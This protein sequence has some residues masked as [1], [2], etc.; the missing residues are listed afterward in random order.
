MAMTFPNYVIIN[1]STS[2]VWSDPAVHEPLRR[3]IAANPGNLIQAVTSRPVKIGRESLIVEAGLT[4][5]NRS[6]P[7]AVKQYRPRTLWKALAALFRPAKAMQNW[8]KAEFLLS[9]DIATPQPLLACRPRGWTTTSTSFLVTP[10]IENSENLHLFGWRI[11]NR[12]IAAR[13]RVASQCAEALGRLIRRMHDAGAPHRDLKAANLLVVEECCDVTVYL[14]DLDG[15]QPGKYVSFKRQARDL[16]RLAAGLSAHPWVTRSICRR[17]LRA[18]LRQS[19]EK[20]IDWKP[21][22]R[23]IAKETER[24]ICHKQKRGRQVL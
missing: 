22:W 3:S 7:V 6:I 1:T 20:C 16:A 18:Y 14:I 9:H 23:A 11:A 15:L 8:R 13:L 12:P 4:V 21:F 17:F 5:G 19:P 24:I 10:W 2:T